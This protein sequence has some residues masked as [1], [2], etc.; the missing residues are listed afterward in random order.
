MITR[1]LILLL[2]LGFSSSS[3]S[4]EKVDCDVVEAG[5][6]LFGGD[7]GA[8]DG[9]HGR[10][11]AS[12]G[13]RRMEEGHSRRLVAGDYGNSSVLAPLGSPT[14]WIENYCR[15]THPQNFCDCRVDRFDDYF[16]SGQS[17]VVR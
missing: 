7:A 17:D 12:T 13:V 11:L 3:S 10:A 8:F 16:V 14:W 5:G 9:E 4:S 1:L 2:L 6:G 15:Q